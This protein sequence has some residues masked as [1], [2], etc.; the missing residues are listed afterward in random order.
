MIGL[1]CLL[2]LRALTEPR[3]TLAQIDWPRVRSQVGPSALAGGLTFAVALIATSSVPLAGTLGLMALAVPPLW[4]SHRESERREELR[5]A[6]P[7]AL[8]EVVGSIRAGLSAGEAL[9]QLG[10]RGPELLRP[11]FA[12]FAVN[13]RASGRLDPCLDELKE[14]LADP[15]ADRILEAMRIAHHLGGRDLGTML[16]SLASFVRE[17]NRT[18]G[19]LLARQSWTVQGA[20]LAAAAPWLILLLLS[21]RPGTIEAYATPTGGLVLGFGAVATVVA[22]VLMVRLGRLP[23]ERRTLAKTAT[24]SEGRG[25]LRTRRAIRSAQIAPA[26]AQPKQVEAPQ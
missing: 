20:R 2:I 11:Y 24:A 15:M 19:E 21:T 8:D 26:E 5:G 17:D 12:D 6:W 9:A 1:G 14:N 16:L 7:E 23:E 25:Q 10:T 4:R 13:L 18:R 3:D 22:Y